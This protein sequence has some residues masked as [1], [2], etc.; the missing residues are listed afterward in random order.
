M[1]A[2]KAEA[3][4]TLKAELEANG[5]KVSGRRGDDR[6]IYFQDPDGHRLQLMFKK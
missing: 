4:E 1:P 5:V 3:I 2:R 6:C